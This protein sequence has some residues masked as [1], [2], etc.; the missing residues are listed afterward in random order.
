MVAGGAGIKQRV[1][2]YRV[3][4]GSVERMAQGENYDGDDQEGDHGD[5][6]RPHNA[7]GKIP[8]HRRYADSSPHQCLIRLARQVLSSG[9]EP[10]DELDE[11]KPPERSNRSGGYLIWM[12][13]LHAGAGEL[14][15]ANRDPEWGA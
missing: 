15:Y 10:N 13:R 6:R 11:V 14:D 3:A 4:A 12:A 8:G 2:G 5:H 1:D 9:I 7:P